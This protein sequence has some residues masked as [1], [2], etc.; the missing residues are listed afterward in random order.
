MFF[1]PFEEL[2]L[3]VPTYLMDPQWTE[4]LGSHCCGTCSFQ[5]IYGLTLLLSSGEWILTNFVVDRGYW[6]EIP[7]TGA[8]EGQ[9][10]AAMGA[11]RQEAEDGAQ[12]EHEGASGDAAGA[13]HPQVPRQPDPV[14]VFVKLFSFVPTPVRGDCRKK[15]H[16]PSH[17]GQR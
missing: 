6:V 12:G 15:T 16:L 3:T 1:M 11:P 5:K 17:L 13:Q 9:V 14:Q 7:V 2:K 10:G 8:V 4:H